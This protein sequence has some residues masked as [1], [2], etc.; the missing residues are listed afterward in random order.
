MWEILKEYLFLSDYEL[1]IMQWED[2]VLS[3]ENKKEEL[4]ITRWNIQNL[5][6]DESIL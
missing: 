5:L 2:M 6:R 4:I 3:K 1:I